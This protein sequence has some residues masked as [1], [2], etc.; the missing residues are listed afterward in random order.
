MKKTASALAAASLLTLTA[1]FAPACAQAPEA[2]EKAETTDE[3]SSAFSLKDTKIVGSLTYG[4][5]SNPTAYTKTPRYR[6]FKFA[7]QAGDEVDIWVRSNN[8][9]P[10]TWLL[11]NDWKIV[12]KNDDAGGTTNSHITAK[13]PSNESATH[14]IVV[15]D[16]DLSAM[17]FR[18]E[19]K[20]K[21]ADF[22]SG[23]NLDADCVKVAKNCCTNLGNTAVL[24]GKE[25]AYRASLGCQEPLICPKIATI[26]DHSMA[27][28]N[29]ATHKCEL[30][31]PADIACNGFIMN[32]H[33]CP[34]NYRCVLPIGKPDVPG[35]CRQFCGGIAAFQCSDPNEECVDD[36][37][38]N[39]D[40]A[41]GGA[42]CGGICQ[43]KAPKPT[44]CRTNGCGAG[45]WCSYCWGSFACIPTGALC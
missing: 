45:K 6:A 4:E 29:T 32:A 1:L 28:C 15:R 33:Q 40:P 21:S 3:Q 23:C 16:Y 13:L 26:D 5:T 12:A 24:E 41:K 36:P 18:V 22:V 34:E 44:D 17:N 38:D 19:L 42:D 11:N 25:A 27:E 2:E 8:G 39:C 20:G 35:K 9:D 10:V 31:K 43:P 14:Y 7:G 30:V 37:S